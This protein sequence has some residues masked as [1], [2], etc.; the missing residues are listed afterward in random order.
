MIE[1]DQ[2][3]LWPDEG[4]NQPI[5]RAERL[6]SLIKWAGGKEQELKHILPSIPS[7]KAYYEPFVGGGAVFFSIQ[8][9]RKFINDKSPD[10][11]NLYTMTA[12][13]NQ[14]FFRSLDT[15]LLG[16][17]RVSNIVDRC[18]T[19]LLNTYTAY[20]MDESSLDEMQIRLYK[21]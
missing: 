4:P 3:V 19:E 20:S 8:S 7:F 9:Q 10:L 2:T 21:F 14:D 17:Q 5:L 16:W 12:Q 1:Y 18:T 6:T 11:V 15:L 13:Q